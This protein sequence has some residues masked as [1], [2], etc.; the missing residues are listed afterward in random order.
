M[1]GNDHLV[2][3]YKASLKNL[4]IQYDAIAKKKH[5]REIKDHGRIVVKIEDQ[6]TAKEIA[7]QKL[8]GA[9]ISDCLY[10]LYW[11]EHGYEK[12]VTD[13]DFR[14]RSRIKREQLWGHIEVAAAYSGQISHR[15]DEPVQLDKA[16]YNRQLKQILSC[17]SE[18]EREY[19]ILKNEA[20]LTEVECAK[21]LNISLGTVKSMGQRIRNKIDYFLNF[22]DLEELNS[23]TEKASVK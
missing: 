4:R 8:L 20:M 23:W 19:F 12:P 14:K 21:K 15:N 3:E 2:K 11:L 9:M 22:A 1:S 17:L 18:R 7:D 13:V 5:D 10:T 6:R 16:Y